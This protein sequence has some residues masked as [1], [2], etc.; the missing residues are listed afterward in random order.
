MNAQEL[1]YQILAPEPEG[2]VPAENLFVSIMLDDQRTFVPGK[3]RI[4]L[5]KKPIYPE[6]KIQQHTL[7]FIHYELLRNGRNYLRIFFKVQGLSGW[8]EVEWHFF[9]NERTPENAK[10]GQRNKE[11]SFGGTISFDNREQFLTGP[12]AA[13]RQ[14]PPFTR[15]LTANTRLVLDRVTIPFQMFAT[16]DNRPF[17]QSRN[18]FQTGLQTSWFEALVGDL[19]P[20]FDRLVLSGVR[21]TGFSTHVKVGGS[22]LH[23]VHGQLNRPVEGRLE[24]WDEKFGTIPQNMINDSQLVVPGTYQRNLTAVR[25]YV[26]NKKKTWML[27]LQGLKAKDDTSSIQ[28]GL[29]PKDNLVGGA[30]FQARLFRRRVLLQSGISLSAI[31]NDISLG[32]LSNQELDTNYNVKLPFDPSAFQRIF[33]INSSTKPTQISTDFVSYFININWST[34]W[35]QMTA[36][37]SRIGPQ[38]FSLSN[39]FLRNNTDNLLF[40]E[41]LFLFKKKL[42]ITGIYQAYTNNLNN[43][44][45]STLKTEN[46][47][48]GVQ[49][50]ISAK[51][52]TIFFQYNRQSRLSTR[53]VIPGAEVDD[54]LTMFNGIISYNVQRGRWNTTFRLSG[55][56]NERTDRIRPGSSNTFYNVMIGLGERF[57]SRTYLSLDFGKTLLYSNVQEKLS[58]VNAFNVNLLYDLIENKLQVS[59][60]AGNNRSLSSA[61]NLPQIRNSFIMRVRYVVVKGLTIDLEGGWQP[62]EDRNTPINNYQDGYA[63]ARVSYDFF[64]SNRSLAR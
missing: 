46:Y 33:V 17:L 28:Y 18:F 13:L 16:S 55:F 24:R 36:D 26:G 51:Y 12:G 37:Y 15:T 27:A 59:A 4:F 32:V 7:S 39:P 50:N 45:L 21:I 52:P 47:G 34:S 57:G 60:S 25:M 8:Q 64:V 10:E 14:E 62:F 61:W 48:A 11:Y 56:L 20:A 9:V 31:T 2:V 6:I 58:D 44:L 22:G 1:R 54:Y 29:A 3:V 40:Q 5:N 35:H 53:S 19:N 38:Y 63:Y 41:R 42:T 49:V 23:I 43:A 30:E